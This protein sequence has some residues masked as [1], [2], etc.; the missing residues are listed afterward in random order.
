M[1]NLKPAPAKAPQ[2]HPFRARKKF[3]R[4]L[5]VQSK[6][7]TSK[8]IKSNRTASPFLVLQPPVSSANPRAQL[9]SEAQAVG[10]T[11]FVAAGL[12]LVIDCKGY[13]VI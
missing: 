1:G 6:N 13:K 7:T 2:S 8:Y 12:D 9:L 10:G 11:Q 4:Y 5:T 3:C